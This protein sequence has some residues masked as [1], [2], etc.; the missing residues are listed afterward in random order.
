MYP[1]I[2]GLKNTT[3]PAKCKPPYNYVD[4]KL[5]KLW[6]SKCSNTKT[7]KL[8]LGLKQSTVELKKRLGP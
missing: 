7:K 1:K 6:F 8:P 5:K 3:R 2:V 4:R